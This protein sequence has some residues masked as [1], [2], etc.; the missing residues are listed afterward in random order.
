LVGRPKRR[1]KDKAPA[2]PVVPRPVYECRYCR[3]LVEKGKA[4]PQCGRSLL[5]D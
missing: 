2:L 3:V 5:L 1:G 4:C